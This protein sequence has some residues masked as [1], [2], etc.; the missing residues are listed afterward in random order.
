[1]SA[2]RVGLPLSE[3]GECFPTTPEVGVRDEEKSH[4]HL[5]NWSKKIL[6]ILRAYLKIN[7]P[8]NEV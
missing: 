5:A 6:P 2:K 7:Y 3:V 4:N 1:M 8:T